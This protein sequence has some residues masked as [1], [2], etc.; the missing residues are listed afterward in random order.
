MKTYPSFLH[1]F[2]FLMAFISLFVVIAFFTI[3]CVVQ[4]L[5]NMLGLQGIDQEVLGQQGPDF[6][7]DIQL[8]CM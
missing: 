3:H 5:K 7:S 8:L 1:G 6:H 4:I 2:F